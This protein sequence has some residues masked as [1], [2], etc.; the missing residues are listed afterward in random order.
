MIPQSQMQPMVFRCALSQEDQELPAGVKPIYIPT[1]T[2]L[3]TNTADPNAAPAQKPQAG[4][5]PETTIIDTMTSEIDN[6]NLVYVPEGDFLMGTTD[7]NIDYAIRDLL[8]RY[9]NLSHDSFPSEKPPRQVN[10]DAFWIDQTEVT[11]AMYQKCIDDNVCEPPATM[12]SRTRESYFDN[13][14]YKDH[15]VIH[16]NWT[17]AETYLCLGRTAF[18][19]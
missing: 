18:A 1:A 16:I 9:P 6:M 14:E 3:P 4:S 15:P 2:P 8:S 11:N 5:T 12:A 7:E 17:Q 19:H 13:P 10:L